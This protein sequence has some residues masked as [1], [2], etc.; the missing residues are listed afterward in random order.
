MTYLNKVNSGTNEM[1]AAHRHCEE[2]SNDI[3]KGIEA[4]Q[5]ISVEEAIVEAILKHRMTEEEGNACIEAYY[6][7][8]HA[9]PDTQIS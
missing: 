2:W 4:A 7:T 8:F 6:R 1:E 9:P 5:N 3:D